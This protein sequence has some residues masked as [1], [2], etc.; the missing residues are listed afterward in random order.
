[1]QEKTLR[2]NG[3]RILVGIVAVLALASSVQAYQG[4]PMRPLQVVGRHLKD[5]TGKIVMLHGW[6]APGGWYWNG[7]AFPDPVEYTPQEC[8]SALQVYK[9][10]V[11]VLTATNAVWGQSHGSFHS[12]VRFGESPGWDAVNNLQNADRFD[13]YINNLLVPYVDYCAT[14]GLYVCFIGGAATTNWMSAQHKANLIECFTRIARHPG[15]KNKANVMFEICNEPVDIETEPGNDQWGS[16]TVAHD[17]AIQRYM[18]DIA[19]AIR[20]TGAT[21]VVWIPGL[22]WQGR[23]QNFS[24][25]PVEGVN[26]GYAGHWYPLGEDAPTNILNSFTNDWKQCSDVAPIIVTEGSWNTMATNQGLRTG[27]TAGFG[28]TQRLIRDTAENFSWMAGMNSEVIGGVDWPPG[29]TN[30]TFPEIACGQAAFDWF[31][32]YTWCAP[33][34][35]GAEVVLEQSLAVGDKLEIKSGQ[36]GAQSFKYGPASGG[37]N[38]QISKLR[39]FLS[40]SASAPTA[41]L[42]VSLGT[43]LNGGTIA[44]STTNITPASVTDSSGGSTFMIRDIA[45]PTPLGPLAAG[46]TYYINFSSAS[47]NGY[48]VQMSSLADSHTGTVDDLYPRGAAFTNSTDTGKDVRFILSG[49]ELP[50]VPLPPTS[51]TAMFGGGNQIK[52]SW[53]DSRIATGYN[54]KRSTSSGGPFTTIAANTT[55][56]NFTDTGLVNGTTYYYVVTAVNPAGESA[57]SAPA[58]ATPV[59]KLAGTVIGSSGS[60]GGDGSTMDKVF[61]G[62][63]GTYYDA[64]NGSGD[65]AGMDIGSVRVVSEIKYCPRSGNAGR[66]VGGQFQ[67]ANVPD[68]SSGVVTLF[69]ITTTPTEGVLT[70]RTVSN[71]TAFRY[72]RYIGPANGFCNVAEVEFW[73]ANT[74]T[75]PPAA[76]TGLAATGSSQQ[77]ALNWNTSSGATSYVVKRS[78]TS[79]GSYATIA[80]V[81]GASFTDTGLPTNRLYYSSTYYYVVS[82]VNANGEGVNSA[83]ARGTMPP[84]APPRL[85][86]T[87][88]Q[89]HATLW[90]DFPGGAETYI[91][92]RSTTSGGPYTTIVTNLVN[93]NFTDPELMN[94]TNCYYVVSAVNAGGEGANST[95]VTV[96]PPY[97]WMSCEIGAGGG[98]ASFSNGVFSVGG[99][100][101]DIWGTADACRFVYMPVTGNCTIVARVVAVENTD[102]WSKAGVMIRASLDANAANAFMAVTP[103]NGVTF[104]YRSSADGNSANNNTTDLSA[105][106]W[107]RLVRSGNS[108]SGYR[109]TNGVNWTQQGSSTTISMASTVYVGLAVTAHNSSALCTATFDNVTLPGW[110]NWTLPPVPGGLAGSADNGRAALTWQVS[111]T[112]TS[113]NV[114]RSTTN[115]GPYSIIANITTLNYTDTGLTNGMTYYYLVSAVNP[116]GESTNSVQL[117]LSPR[118]LVSL[119]LAETNLTL[120]WPLAS[121]GFTLQSRTNLVLGNWGNVTSPVPQ[122]VGTN[123]QVTLPQAVDNSSVFYRLS[124]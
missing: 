41:D 8:A 84:G 77:I 78:T 74:G 111:S 75:P 65:W 116:A 120:S 110:S 93:N 121:T 108:F 71:S 24:R 10:Q 12:F 112:A 82:A 81:S 102:P 37:P 113:Y 39:L 33:S 22:V 21:N 119:T 97:P 86:A 67:G 109:S 85:T 25:N 48:F 123:W 61:D 94:G 107:V 98:G 16:S 60:W 114:K 117:A 90:W 88:N 54:V 43:T 103:S 19:D 20:G 29:G 92:K 118:P 59:A 105:P 99:S 66:M 2:M 47:A 14:R 106:Y 72:L 69:T 73:A 62:D 31:P 100:G 6:M 3:W 30:Y 68:F 34:S 9:M 56:N 32:S 28:K 80:N 13:R 63:L 5:D 42:V 46:T 58:S 15:I 64:V 49:A 18:Q 52:L 50:T 4:M 36:T 35:G 101:S 122:I 55:R 40:K 87:G 104:Q 83:Q 76:P 44:N 79:G 27:T 96:N 23:L 115:G 70:V 7:R 45:F 95:E 57:N 51:F 53:V 89:R 11:D 91:V 1:M 38:F 17:R 124:K 26:I